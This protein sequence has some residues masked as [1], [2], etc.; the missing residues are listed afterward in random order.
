MESKI[1]DYFFSDTRKFS[2]RHKSVHWK[3]SSIPEKALQVAAIRVWKTMIF[4]VNLRMMS[5]TQTIYSAYHQIVTVK[6][7]KN[8]SISKNFRV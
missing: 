2:K 7:T 6:I 5:Q 4:H 8:V 3:L 1:F